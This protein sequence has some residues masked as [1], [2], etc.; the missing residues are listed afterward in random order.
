M[1]VANSLLAALPLTLTHS[2]ARLHSQGTLLLSRSFVAV[3]DCC[4][5]HCPYNSHFR[6]SVSLSLSHAQ[7]WII[8]RFI[9]SFNLHILV[10]PSLC[11]PIDWQ[12]S[13]ICLHLLLFHRFP[14]ALCYCD[15]VC[16]IVAMH[17]CAAYT[18]RA[19]RFYSSC[20]LAQLGDVVIHISMLYSTAQQCLLDRV[21]NLESTK[22]PTEIM[23]IYVYIHT[24]SQ[25]LAIARSLYSM[26]SSNGYWLFLVNVAQSISQ[27]VL[28]NDL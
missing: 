12:C 13:F 9:N 3:F 24:A 22:C 25:S 19:I 10:C 23:A 17:I 5:R 14:L 16:P 6:L 1:L 27:N 28:R 15:C 2:L 18:F 8:V 21:C 7:R 20:F 26:H 11:L 4:R